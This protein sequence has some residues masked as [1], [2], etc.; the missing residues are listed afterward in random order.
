MFKNVNSIADKWRHIIPP[1]IFN[2][3]RKPVNAILGPVCFS[4]ETGHLRSSFKSL[5]VDKKGGPLPWYTYPAIEWLLL[6]DLSGTK[7]LEFGCGQSTKFWANK[8]ATVI[9]FEDDWKWY[10]DLYADQAL[11]NKPVNIHFLKKDAIITNEVIVAV[12]DI[13]FDYICVD[14][15]HRGSA[16][17]QAFGM[18]G[19]DTIVIID[20]SD[21]NH[22]HLG[23]GYNE[24][25]SKDFGLNRLDFIGYPPG[26]CRPHCTS[27]YFSPFNKKLNNKTNNPNPNL[28]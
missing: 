6:R 10:C 15:L 3:L 23:K 24:M 14:G 13:K 1:A 28:V 5:A 9:G 16:A 8:G 4:L 26:N 11:Y 22:V 25:A 21:G 18:M 20:N 12:A 17:A 2:V 19:E 27:I 7:V